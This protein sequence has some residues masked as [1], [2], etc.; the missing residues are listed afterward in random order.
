MG[1]FSRCLEFGLD[2]HRR[3]SLSASR[4]SLVALNLRLDRTTASIRISQTQQVSRL[5]DSQAHGP[6][7][8]VTVF[9][10]PDHPTEF[11]VIG[12]VYSI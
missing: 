6:L 5:L 10:P 1:N 7:H 4:P 3:D 12:G 11:D 9:H 8:S 2:L